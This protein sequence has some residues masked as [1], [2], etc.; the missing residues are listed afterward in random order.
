MRI[1]VVGTGR[2]GTSTFYHA[3]KHATNYHVG[4]ESRAGRREPNDYIYPDQTLEI[5]CH[6]SFAVPL[7]YERNGF[8]DV[9]IVHLV[10][11][12]RPCIESLARVKDALQSL[13]FGIQ[14]CKPKS[15]TEHLAWAEWWY[16][17]VNENI[18]AT[19]WHPF[20]FQME[21]AEDFW[22]DFWMWAGCEGDFD[23][24]MEEWRRKYNAGEKLGRDAWVRV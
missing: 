6:L 18:S 23:A 8:H 1:F 11:E 14:Q 9:K 4:H 3:A 24:S 16:D 19:A 12:R 10:R 2:C 20:E 13:A 21:A 15:D 7:L 22:P 17:L 5:S